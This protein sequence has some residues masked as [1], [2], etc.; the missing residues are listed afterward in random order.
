MYRD[1]REVTKILLSDKGKMDASSLP[2]SKMRRNETKLYVK[3]VI[4]EIKKDRESF[5]GFAKGKGFI[6]TREKFLKYLETE[7]GEE[8]LKRVRHGKGKDSDSASDTASDKSTKTTKNG[9]EKNSNTAE[10]ATVVVH[11]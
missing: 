11:R 2:K 9:K 1:W 4:E 3:W 5:S 10:V 7:Q 8:E 6:A